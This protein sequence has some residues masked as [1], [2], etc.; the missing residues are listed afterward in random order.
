MSQNIKH[1]YSPLN[2]F[3]CTHKPFKVPQYIETR[4]DI[5]KIITNNVSDPFPPTKLNLYRVD[6][7]ACDYGPEQNSCLN[8]W[9]MIN[10][11]YNMKVKAPYIGICHY[12][13][14]FMPDVIERLDM[15]VLTDSGYEMAIG[16]PVRFKDNLNG[17]Y[18]NRTWWAYWH[19]LADYDFMES[20]VKK[21]YPELSETIDTVRE[22]DYLYNSAMMI[23]SRD[24]FNDWCEFSFDVY[25]LL[26]DAYG[27]KT[28]DDVLQYVMERKDEYAKPSLPYYNNPTQFKRLIGFGMERFATAVWLHEKRSD[29]TSILDHAAE[30]QWFM[31]KEEEIE[32]PQKNK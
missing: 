32:L 12:R 28:D 17:E 1:K 24:D 13:R 10:A 23:L 27:F 21:A 29:G 19:R 22:C 14:Y 3:I 20:V 25:D 31:P 6:K 30:I 7:M 2:I 8:E 11:I 26:M 5:Y 16:Q 4:P 18:N 15:N 9:R